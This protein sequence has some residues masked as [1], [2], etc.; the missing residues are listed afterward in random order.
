[1]I[2][3]ARF[4]GQLTSSSFVEYAGNEQIIE[5]AIS[6]SLGERGLGNGSEFDT[7]R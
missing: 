2:G 4:V 7:G 6:L 1:M 3:A 5:D